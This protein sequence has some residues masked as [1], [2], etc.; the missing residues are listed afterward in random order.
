MSPA[1]RPTDN[2]VFGPLTGGSPE[3]TY[4]GVLS[5]MRRRY[6]R[7]IQGVD[8]VVWGVPFDAATSNRPGARFGPQAIRRASAILDGDPQYPFGLDPFERLT[9]VDWGDCALDYGRPASATEE[10]AAQAGEILASGAQLVTLG[11]DHS[12][13]LGLLRA[14]AT[15][16]GPLALVQ[17]DA[18][19]DTW[20]AKDA[21]RIDH[22]SVTARAVAEGLVDPARSIQ[23]GVRTVAPATCD[24]DVI[25][26]YTFADIGVKGTVERIRQRVG[27]GAA[28]LSFDIDALDPAFAPG[29]GTPVAGGLTSRE[30]LTIL[31]ALGP[32]D[33]RGMDVVEVSPPYDHADI[34]AIAASAIAMHYIGLLAE[35]RRA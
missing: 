22:G 33:W 25:D 18:H 19:Q 35:R 7:Q 17:F 12:I 32:I 30:A 31:R 20:H 9:V 26:A 27:S 21:T 23:I 2:A 3:P 28:Y 16:Y 5:F 24:L 6:S 34:T 15:L 11:G 1:R 8:V 14:H 10:I 29:T 13:T 4:G